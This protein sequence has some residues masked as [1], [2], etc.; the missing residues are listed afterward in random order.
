MH[1]AANIQNL[2]LS[3]QSDFKLINISTQQWWANN[4]CEFNYFDNLIWDLQYDLSILRFDLKIVQSHEIAKIKVTYCLQRKS[5]VYRF[6]LARYKANILSRAGSVSKYWRYH[7]DFTIPISP[8]TYLFFNILISYRWQLKF[9][10]F[11]IS[12]Y[13]FPYCFTRQII[14]WAKLSRP[15]VSHLTVIHCYISVPNWKLTTMSTSGLQSQ[16]QKNFGYFFK[17][18]QSGLPSPMKLCLHVSC[19][20]SSGVLILRQLTCWLRS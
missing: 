12:Y 13:T 1:T 20:Y 8:F 15:T 18:L 9:R 7:N 16:K 17:L 3:S 6:E 19:Y 4:Q 2:I 5:H 10:Q 11:S 14:I